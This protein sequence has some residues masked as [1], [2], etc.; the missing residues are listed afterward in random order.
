MA[1]IKSIIIK[2]WLKLLRIT[3]LQLDD[4]SKE[5]F[6]MNGLTNN[7]YIVTGQQWDIY[8]IKQLI[9]M[10]IVVYAHGLS[11]KGAWVSFWTPKPLKS[12][13]QD[14]QIF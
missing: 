13:P 2:K 9:A 5:F 3:V 10:T 1:A 8:W 6:G 14:T 7:L 4:T 12:T 11:Q